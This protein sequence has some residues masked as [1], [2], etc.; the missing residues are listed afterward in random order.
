MGAQY[1][2]RADEFFVSGSGSGTGVNG[3][4]DDVRIYNRALS[5][6][7]VNKLYQMGR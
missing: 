4:V 2:R 1:L 3:L 6:G 5:A 7:E